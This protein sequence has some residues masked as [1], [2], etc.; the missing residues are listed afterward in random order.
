MDFGV[1]GDRS[2]HTGWLNRFL[3]AAGMS[4][5]LGAVTLG[6]RV[7]K[8]LRGPA[9][10]IAMPS[11]SEF[12]PTG[13]LTFRR[14]GIEAMYGTTA[15][16]LLTA[17][18]GRT[19]QSSDRIAAVPTA[20]GVTY[21][22]SQVG[23]ALKD[24]AALIKADIGLRLG[25][26]DFGGWDHHFDENAQLPDMLDDLSRSLAAFAQDLGTD[27][28]RTVVLV[29]T[30]FG[31]RLAENGAHG[32]DHGRGG[33]MLAMGGGLAGGRVLLRDDVWPGLAPENLEGGIDL[34][35]S[36]DFRNVFAEVLTRHMGLVDAGPVFPGHTLDPD[37]YPGLFV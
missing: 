6:T 13:T 27:L 26:V 5:P 4:D 37:L 16:T 30:E 7:G 19:F 12:R 36:T 8:S 18:G 23:L 3:S 25:T 31:R 10:T 15:N 1:P 17:L 2:V 32:T 34:P 33:V 24:L 35:V 14:P 9:P 11:I 22:N 21:P 28:D 20:T 29:M